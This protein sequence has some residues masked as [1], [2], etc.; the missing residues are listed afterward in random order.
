MLLKQNGSL[1]ALKQPVSREENWIVYANVVRKRS[2]ILCKVNSITVVKDEYLCQ[3]ELCLVFGSIIKEL[4]IMS[5]SLLQSR[6]INSDVYC[7][8]LANLNKTNQRSAA[9]HCHQE[10]GSVPRRQYQT[11]RVFGNSKLQ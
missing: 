9:K 3:K 2:W 1:S 7:H 11:A 8:Q 4:L 6:T 10:K 5:F